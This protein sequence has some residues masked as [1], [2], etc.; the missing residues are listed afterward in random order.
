MCKFRSGISRSHISKSIK[1][2]LLFALAFTVFYI[3]L[4]CDLQKVDQGHRV[5][6][7]QLRHSMAKVKI[8]TC[9]PHILA[10]A[11]TVSDI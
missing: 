1:L 10:L 7:S 9:L 6:F 11:L 3:I 4:N 5:Q 2:V 8:Y